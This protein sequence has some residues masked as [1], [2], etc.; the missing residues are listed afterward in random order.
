MEKHLWVLRHATAEMGSYSLPD[1]ERN[2]TSQ[3]Q[4]EAS[5]VGMC[6]KQNV[7][8]FD[9]IVSSPAVRTQQTAS[10]VCESA[11][12]SF[13]KVEWD[14]RI[15]EASIDTLMKVVMSYSDD[16]SCIV[17][18]GHNPGLEMLISGSVMS[19]SSHKVFLQPAS[20]AHIIFPT[21]WGEA[22]GGLGKLDSITHV[23]DCRAC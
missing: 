17:L 14:S 11:G 12:F 21:S 5:K 6:L 16:L 22:L 9:A 20:L 23:S 3:G 1:F 2:L 18:I 13:E 15:Y 19:P 8:T 4:T 10:A 7:G